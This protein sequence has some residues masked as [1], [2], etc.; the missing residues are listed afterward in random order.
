MIILER[1]LILSEFPNNK[2][3][4]IVFTSITV[5]FSY[6]ELVRLCPTRNKDKSASSTTVIQHKSRDSGRKQK[7]SKHTYLIIQ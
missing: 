4:F 3:C 7:R 2:K 6:Y 5:S 1:M